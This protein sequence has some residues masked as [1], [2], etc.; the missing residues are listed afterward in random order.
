MEDEDSDDETRSMSTIGTVTF[1]VSK[2]SDEVSKHSGRYTTMD[3]DGKDGP[4]QSP[5]QL[6]SGRFIHRRGH[7]L[8]AQ[9]T[10]RSAVITTPDFFRQDVSKTDLQEVTLIDRRRPFIHTKDNRYPFEE[11][12]WRA[13]RVMMC[14]CVAHWK[15][16]PRL[17]D[18]IL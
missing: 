3:P 6:Q 14:D 11:V 15:G 10:N 7:I 1:N 16:G 17:E 12:S 9:H 18:I 5:I 13:F 8:S 2:H 4:M